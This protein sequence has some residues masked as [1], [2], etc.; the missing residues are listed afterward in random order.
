M[1]TAMPA[2]ISTA[3]FDSTT[4]AALGVTPRIYTW[5]WGSGANADSATLYAGVPVP[6]SVPE[7]ASALLLT[8]G[9]AG[10]ALLTRASSTR[11]RHLRA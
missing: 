1:S 10:L 3:T 6:S 4:L 7:P 5:T 2:A 11:S 8:L 9:A